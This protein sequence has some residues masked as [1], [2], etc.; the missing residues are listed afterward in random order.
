MSELKFCSA[1]YFEWLE[2]IYDIVGV[3]RC[4]GISNALTLTL[5]VI[6]TEAMVRGRTT[7]LQITHKSI[8][9]FRLT[10]QSVSRALDI[11]EKAKV[12][13]VL[14][15]CG[16]SPVVDLL[17]APINSKTASKS[18]KAIITKDIM[19][20]NINNDTTTIDV[21]KLKCKDNTM[22]ELIRHWEDKRLM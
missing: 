4:G 1:I 16:R 20:T 7:D 14:R 15:V 12:I 18:N 19:E 21:S 10:R 8:N 5:I 13:K 2:K 9:R 22:N 6:H 3:A 11:L 17:I